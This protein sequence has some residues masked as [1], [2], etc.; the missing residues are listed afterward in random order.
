MS[1]QLRAAAFSRLVCHLSEAEFDYIRTLILLLSAGERVEL[2][3]DTFRSDHSISSYLDVGN[4]VYLE[5]VCDPDESQIL[6]LN[7]N[8]V[9][10]ITWYFNLT[11]KVPF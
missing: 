8:Q 7:A 6:R 3:V 11:N 1:Y 2:P 5:G 10:P 9:V 4:G